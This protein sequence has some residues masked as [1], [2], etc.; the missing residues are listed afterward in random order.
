MAK[1]A[2]IRR[3]HSVTTVFCDLF[4]Y[5]NYELSLGERSNELGILPSQILHDLHFI[6]RNLD[7]PLTPPIIPLLTYPV[8]SR[9]PGT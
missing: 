4:Y 5:F 7:T 3:A 9:Y 2:A 1:K 8:A 6:G